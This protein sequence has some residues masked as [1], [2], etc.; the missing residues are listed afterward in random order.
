M[1]ETAQGNVVQRQNS[2]VRTKTGHA[3]FGSNT[4]F[5]VLE[6]L[7]RGAYGKS[8]KKAK[9]VYATLVLAETGRVLVL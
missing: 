5:P 9:A 3:D 8:K 1:P 6:I 7:S 2:M 4:N